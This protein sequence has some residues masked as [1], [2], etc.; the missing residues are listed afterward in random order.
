MAEGGRTEV[1]DVV[2]EYRFRKTHEFIAVNA[3]VLLETFSEP[4]KT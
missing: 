2:R 3:G 4:V 1:A